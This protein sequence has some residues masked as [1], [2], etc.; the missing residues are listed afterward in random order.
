MDRGFEGWQISVGLQW[1][2]IVVGMICDH[3]EI[4]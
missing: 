2:M 1:E 3:V 4:A